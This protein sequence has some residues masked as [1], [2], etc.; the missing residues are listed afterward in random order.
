MFFASNSKVKNQRKSIK[1]YF[2]ALGFFP[3]A[4][5]SIPTLTVRQRAYVCLCM[6][7]S[8]DKYKHLPLPSYLVVLD[9]LC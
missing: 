8:V 4:Y 1:D 2:D 6:H 9:L 7:V 5:H 3:V